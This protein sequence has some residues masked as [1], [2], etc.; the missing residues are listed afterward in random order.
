MKE[1]RTVYYIHSHA[2]IEC[3]C[4]QQMVLVNFVSNVYEGKCF[5]DKE[6]KLKN[7]KLF[8][9]QELNDITIKTDKYMGSLQS[10]IMEGISVKIGDTIPYSDN[11]ENVHQME[12]KKLDS[13]DG[14]VI[15]VTGINPGNKSTIVRKLQASI[16]LMKQQSDK[17]LATKKFS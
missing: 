1:K 9:V 5:C 3:D 2:F 4:G 16:E 7:N 14:G 11:N 13:T 6:F 10:T 15:W 12:V 8:C 17:F